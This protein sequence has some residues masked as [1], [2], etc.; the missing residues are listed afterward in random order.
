MICA[1]STSV[2]KRL[3]TIVYL[4]SW[5]GRRGERDELGF[6][7]TGERRPI[8]ALALGVSR[9]LPA[10]CVVAHFVCCLL[11]EEHLLRRPLPR[12]GEC[13]LCPV[14]RPRVSSATVATRIVPRTRGALIL[15]LLKP[16][17][18]CT[19]LNQL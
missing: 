8:W 1:Y 9:R 14:P 12:G 2:H 18:N 13:A 6:L 10:V 3:H 16:A 11:W 7:G 15:A 4:A 17:P 19:S 5:G